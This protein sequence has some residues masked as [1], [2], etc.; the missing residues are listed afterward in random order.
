[1]E[2]GGRGRKGDWWHEPVDKGRNASAKE[3][4]GKKGKTGV[5][6]RRIAIKNTRCRRFLGEQGE[7]TEGVPASAA[8]RE[9][10]APKYRES[11]V[12]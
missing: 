11:R 3:E 5:P 7:G 4:N 2:G 1:M 6:L 12:E 9:Q 10:V 8:S